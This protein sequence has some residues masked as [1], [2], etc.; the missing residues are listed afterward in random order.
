MLVDYHLH[1]VYS[2]HAKGTIEEYLTK[3]EALGIEEVCFT[4]H[5][6]RQY[7]TEEAKARIPYVWM[8]DHELSLYLEDLAEAA[9][10]TPL[11]L[12]RGLEVDYFVGF[13]D[14][15]RD[16]LKEWPLDFVMGT[17]HFLP[18]YDMRYVTLVEDAPANLLLEYFGYAKQAVE[19]GLFDSLAHI[20]LPWQAV[21]WPKGDLEKE[22]LQSLAEVVAAAKVQDMCLEINTRAFNFEGYGTLGL[23]QNFLGMLADYD[24]PITMGS[25]AHSP[26]EIGRNYSAIIKELARYGIDEVAVF[27]KRQRAMVPLG[28]ESV[29]PVLG[30]GR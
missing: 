21:P 7:L 12:K 20:H 4:E 29:K 17:I 30:R 26:Q 13:E 28:R 22:V 19:T 27:D 8:Q 14:A 1:T 16:F 6:S 24:V 10:K 25:D 18:A 5:T 11:R 23:Y 9:T 15:L 2:R 3:A